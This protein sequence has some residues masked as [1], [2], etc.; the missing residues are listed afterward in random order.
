MLFLWPSLRNRLLQLQ[1]WLLPVRS[2]LTCYQALTPSSLTAIAPPLIHT[3][4]VRVTTAGPKTTSV[5]QAKTQKLRSFTRDFA[6]LTAQ[7]QSSCHIQ[8][9]QAGTLPILLKACSRYFTV[10][11]HDL[12]SRLLSYSALFA[13][14]ANVASEKAEYT[15]SSQVASR[16]PVLMLLQQ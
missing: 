16:T 5:Q 7:S 15:K 2:S 6:L 3:Q 14:Q 1:N 8:A 13:L 11:H 4:K 9:W 12:L 10:L